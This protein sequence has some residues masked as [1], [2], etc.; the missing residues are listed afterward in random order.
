MFERFSV[1]KWI[2]VV[3]AVLL[4]MVFVGG[5]SADVFKLQMALSNPAWGSVYQFYQQHEMPRRMKETVKNVTGHDLDLVVHPTLVKASDTIDAV[6]EGSVDIGVQMSMYRGD[7]AL[8]DALSFPAVIPFEV[9]PKIH[10][11]LEAIWDKVLREQ[12]GVEP[13][14]I[15]YMPRQLLISKRPAATF[16]TLKGLK[17]RAHSH[18]LLEALRR[19]G[20]APV[21]MPYMEVYLALQKG[22]IDG[23]ASSLSGIA[24]GKW[25]EVAKYVDWWPFG[26]NIHFFVMNKKTWDKLPVDVRT[27][28]REVISNAWHETWVAADLEDKRTKDVFVQKYGCTHLFPSKEEI[29][30][31]AKLMDPVVADWKKKA[32]PHANEVIAVLNE[33]LGTHY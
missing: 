20:G 18:S 23:A 1:G 12:F 27:I 6:R 2:I 26:N 3:F 17:F 7:F 25:Y 24:G 8:M 31:L 15:G 5:A 30:G 4:T 32:G 22:A 21:S 11:R 29:T 9:C 33:A 16:E 14:G 28:I 13:L 19:A 10:T